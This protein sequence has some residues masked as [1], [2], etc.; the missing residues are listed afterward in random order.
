[1]KNVCIYCGAN[2]GSSSFYSRAAV[3][4]GGILA[5]R[6]INLIYGG[7]NVGLMGRLADAVLD[8]KGTVTGVIPRSLSARELGHS[9]V[10]ELLIVESMHE[11]KQRMADLADGFIALPG[12]I[13]TLEEIAEAFTWLQ[14]DFHRKPVALFNIEGYYTPLAELFDHMSGAGFLGTRQKEMLIVDDDFNRLLDR[15]IAFERPA[16]D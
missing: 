15:M 9:G 3:E 12:G 1:M 6:G 13:G 16:D 10:T 11:R 5:K 2:E 7:G 4:C 8:N 14:L